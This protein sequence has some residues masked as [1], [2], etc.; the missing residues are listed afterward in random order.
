MALLFRDIAG[1]SG[2]VNDRR[3]VIRMQEL[4]FDGDWIR[5]V[6]S[7]QSGQPT[8]GYVSTGVFKTTLIGLSNGE[9]GLTLA[10]SLLE[11]RQL[12][13]TI[14]PTGRQ[15]RKL[16]RG[17]DQHAQPE[18][19]YLQ[20]STLSRP[21]PPSTMVMGRPSDSITSRHHPRTSP[22][23]FDGARR[24]DVNGWA[25]NCFGD[26]GHSHR[27]EGNTTRPRDLVRRV[28]PSHKW[29]SR[30]FPPEKATLKMVGGNPTES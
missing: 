22:A 30:K 5:W 26:R 27:D 16:L 21:A 25:G 1:V 24:A 10:N 9:A 23:R 17:V 19:V 8:Q 6:L 28:Q 18:E 4:C 15:S 7:F 2:H 12:R 20:G 3:P 29:M 13:Y 11:N 14:R